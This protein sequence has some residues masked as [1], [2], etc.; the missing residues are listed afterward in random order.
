MVVG[1]ALCTLQKDLE[2]PFS[3]GHVPLSSLSSLGPG[4][5]PDCTVTKQAS[6]ARETSGL[7]VSAGPP[8]APSQLSEGH[9][10]AAG[11]SGCTERQ[12]APAA[13]PL[14]Q[15]SL[16]LCFSSAS[17]CVFP[18]SPFSPSSQPQAPVVW[19]CSLGQASGSA[20]TSLTREW[21]T[22]EQARIHTESSSKGNAARGQSGGGRDELELELRR[23]SR[24]QGGLWA[25]PQRH[26]EIYGHQVKPL[27]R[28]TDRL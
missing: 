28:A 22:P 19:S 4:V 5:V 13:S 27:V 15:G 16:L 25:R 18:L 20:A 21:L 11:G 7:P 24:P 6:P 17:G 14:G 1:A 2:S 26:T 3:L 8:A 10:E 12:Q 23:Q 9:K